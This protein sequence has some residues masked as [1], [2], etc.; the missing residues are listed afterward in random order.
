MAIKTLKIVQQII[1]AYS[2]FNVKEW[3][4]T[5]WNA[6]SYKFQRYEPKDVFERLIKSIEKQLLK[7]PF[8]Y[9]TSNWQPT[10]I[11]FFRKMGEEAGYKVL[12][13][14]EWFKVDCPWLVDLPDIRVVELLMEHE[15]SDSLDKVL[16]DVRKLGDIKSYMKVIIYFPSFKNI[17]VHLQ[18]IAHK[19]QM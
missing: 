13:E 16:D 1:N 3:K 4:I 8:P 17:D 5:T 9:D 19:I 15:D 7:F 11:S 2:T 18:K 6:K 10:M 14:M 12:G